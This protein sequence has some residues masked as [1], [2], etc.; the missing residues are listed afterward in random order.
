MDPFSQKPKMKNIKNGQN[1][2][3]TDKCHDC[4][5]EK[6]QQPKKKKNFTLVF[7]AVDAADRIIAED[8]QNKSTPSMD[9]RF[10]SDTRKRNCK[11]EQR[12]MPILNRSLAT[13]VL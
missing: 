9:S 3:W 13:Q 5:T 4:K 6:Q 12:A 11:A 2:D 1:R 8:W 7:A 10:A